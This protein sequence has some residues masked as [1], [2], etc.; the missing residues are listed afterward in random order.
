MTPTV[1]GAGAP[2]RSMMSSGP[3]GL[4]LGHGPA[5]PVTIRL[6]RP[7]PTR[8]FL[9]TPEWVTW[10]IAFRAV[11]L[12]AHVGHLRRSSAL[13][14]ACGHHPGLRRHDRPVAIR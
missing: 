4:L 5:G 6:F 9:C 14:R 7:D 13:A 3:A 12:G 11:C 2:S 1:G 10:L 8:A